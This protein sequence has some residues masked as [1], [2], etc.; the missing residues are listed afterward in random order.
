MSLAV[1]D[2][3]YFVIV[4]EE[5]N[6]YGFF[7]IVETFIQLFFAFQL[8]SNS[9]NEVTATHTTP[10]K[11]YVDDLTFTFSYQNSTCSVHVSK[12]IYIHT[13]V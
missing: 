11:H 2:T 7:V 3:K 8:L 9:A 5:V 12:N 4:L 1:S 13:Y 10:K 6:I